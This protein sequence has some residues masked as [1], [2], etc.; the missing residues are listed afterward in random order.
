MSGTTTNESAV[1]PQFVQ[2][3]D[4]AL[5]LLVPDVVREHVFSVRCGCKLLA[6]VSL[7]IVKTGVSSTIVDNVTNAQEKGRT[8]NI[9][10]GEIMEN[11]RISAYATVVCFLF[12]VGVAQQNLVPWSTYVS[13]HLKMSSG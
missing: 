4:H 12:G 10:G 2:G 11:S 7:N 13:T 3:V 8:C 9:R 6:V 5:Q 1:G